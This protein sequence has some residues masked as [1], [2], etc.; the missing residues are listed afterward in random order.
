MSTASVFRLPDTLPAELEQLR[1]ITEQFRSGAIP[2]ARYQAFRV[3]QGIYEQRESGTFMLRI[4]LAAGI[5]KPGQMRAAAEVAETYGDG[6]LHLT[7][8]QDLQV[9]GAKVE[10][11][12]PAAARLFEAGLSTKGG[13]GN[14]VRNI[15]ACFQAGVCP[16]ELFD[17]TPH[18]LRLTELLLPD[19][20]SYHLPRKYKIAASGC[21]RDCAGATVN[22]VGFISRRRDGVEGFAVHIGG[23]LGAQS[24]VG[25]LL[26][27][28][29]PAGQAYA[30]AEAV[31]RV[32]DK[33]GNR[34]DRHRARI[35]FLI[36]DLGFEAFERLYRR[37]LM[38]LREVVVDPPVPAAGAKLPP[39]DIPPAPRAEGFREWR[40]W[41]VTPQRQD[42][43]YAVEITPPL[44]VLEAAQLRLLAGVVE[45]HGEGVLRASNWQ[46]A[47]LRWVR[48]ADLPALHAELA[49]VGLGT[50]EPPLLRHMVTCAGAAT[51]RLGICL[52]RGLT[53]ALRRELLH[54]QLDLRGGT[55][56]VVIHV[57][58][59]PNSCGRHPVAQI[60][61]SGAARR[62]HGRLVPHYRVQFGGR[63]EEG[64]TTLATGGL[65]IPARNV[66]AFVVEFLRAFEASREYPDFVA[67]LAERGRRVADELA[68]RHTGPKDKD[69]YVDW[70]DGEPFSLAGRGP[71][72]CG[73]GVFDLIKMD[74]AGADEALKAGR[75][76]AATVLAARA[77]LVTRGEQADSDRQSIELFH[78]RFVEQGLAPEA[79][80][81]LERARRALSS[82]D[83]ER[84]LAATHADV[85][86]LLDAVRK[87]YQSIGP[88]LRIPAPAAVATRLGSY[89]G[90]W[91]EHD[92]VQRDLRRP[93]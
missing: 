92:H 93:R 46:N 63:G 90:I 1:Q 88:S 37:E 41:N 38:E 6:T 68:G 69:F 65:T 18:V 3:P 39:A 52:S 60:G 27:E 66:P 53:R 82:A 73:A 43:F 13:G 71:G 91:N 67:W 5:L 49:D 10:S 76:F 44:G 77:L 47:L 2:G 87:L 58:G 74:L 20:L 4:R 14:T 70:D 85:S 57:S 80:P 55:G 72:E 34:K 42:G 79:R 84:A 61:L 40:E 30:I 33:Y 83:P 45:R 48:E 22:D 35:R 29:I 9:H 28:F 32:F 25:T 11:I 36:E 78:A 19:A 16:Q 23:G 21:G 51:C 24:R 8:R 81:L 15:A 7:S 12:Y 64:R 86:A 54:S 56:N 31:K 50:G 89:P 75:L 17:V 59:C 26:E 62:V